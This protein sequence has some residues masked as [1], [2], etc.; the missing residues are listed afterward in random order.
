MVDVEER[1]VGVIE[2]LVL[3]RGEVRTPREE[4]VLRI[5]LSLGHFEEAV[6]T[7]DRA[8]AEAHAAKIAEAYGK[9]ATMGG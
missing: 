8:R 9:L 3:I 6:A 4:L 7:G 1:L 2:A 5:G